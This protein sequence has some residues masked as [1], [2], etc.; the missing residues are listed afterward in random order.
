MSSIKQQSIKKTY[1]KNKI[2]TS[3]DKNNTIKQIKPKSADVKNKIEILYKE[4]YESFN[5]IS[6]SKHLFQKKLNTTEMAEIAEDYFDQTN[7]EYNIPQLNFTD[8][9]LIDIAEEYFNKTTPEYNIPQ[10]NF[11]DLE[12]IDIAE[13]YFNQ[14]NPEYNDLDTIDNESDI[15]DIAED[16]F[17]QTN[18]EYNM[19]M[20]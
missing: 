20:I 10:L 13:D 5:K 9:E 17:D 16:Y 19:T 2:I 6:F 4:S 1:K 3:I 15:I 7:P 12:L 8:L 18:P 14:T 11:T